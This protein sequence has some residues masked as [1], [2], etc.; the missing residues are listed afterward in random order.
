M[1]WWRGIPN[2]RCLNLEDV[3][4]HEIAKY[5]NIAILSWRDV[6][7]PMD[8]KDSKQR[9]KIKPGM[10]NEDHFHI[11]INSHVQIAWMLTRYSQKVLRNLLSHPLKKHE[12]RKDETVISQ[13]NPLFM[14]IIAQTKPY[15]WSLISTDWRKTS[16]AQSLYVKVLRHKGFYEIT[17]QSPYAHAKTAH[18]GDRFDSFGGW[19]S[20]KGGSFI[21]VSITI[22]KMAGKT[23][24]WTVGLVL[25]HL[26]SGKIK[27]VV[28]ENENN[29]VTITGESYGRIGLQTRIYFLGEIIGSGSHHKMKITTETRKT[30]FQV[31]VSGIV[32]GPAGMKNIKQYKPTDTI[33]KVWSLE[34]YRNLLINYTKLSF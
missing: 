8:S 21:E 11:G 25:R 28:S 33:Q 29:R 20:E 18:L 4:Q 16:L 3:G 32:L 17:P 27:V 14:N 24:N 13:I 34:D 7:C 9:I 30:G 22:P 23:K 26:Q 6:V 31:S 15:C 5:Y 19:R 12:T 2:P 1:K 10:I